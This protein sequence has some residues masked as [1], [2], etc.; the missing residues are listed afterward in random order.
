M[1]SAEP[2]ESL[3]LV[4]RPQPHR[5]TPRGYGFRRHATRG[6]AMGAPAIVIASTHHG[7]VLAEA[8]ARYE[9]EYDVRLVADEATAKGDGHGADDVGPPGRDV[10]G[11][12]RPRPGR[13]LRPDRR[14]P[15]G[16]ARP[17][18]G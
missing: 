9:R 14:H 11:R 8:F 6:S 13:A 17:R 2:D 10:R 18:G 15:E 16:R 7:D 1:E 3:A 5:L 12:Q 4:L